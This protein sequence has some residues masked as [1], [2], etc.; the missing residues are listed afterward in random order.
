MTFRRK[1]Y[2]EKTEDKNQKT[3]E[4]KDK[5]NSKSRPMGALMLVLKSFFSFVLVVLFL[6]LTA[7]MVVLFTPYGQNAAVG[8]ATEKIKES[9]GIDI[10]I[11]KVSL[12]WTTDLFLK[13]V[14]IRDHRADT[15]FCAS[16]LGTSV[17]NY[18]RLYNQN[19]DLS[20]I[21]SKDLVF[22]LKTYK[23]ESK[24]NLDVFIEKF[25]KKDPNKKSTF[26]MN[27]DRVILNNSAFRIYNL[28]DSIAKT[29]TIENINLDT[30]NF[31]IEN[32]NFSISAQQGSFLMNDKLDVRDIKTNFS[33]EKGSI[34]AFNTHIVTPNSNVS[35][36]VKFTA[37]DGSFS[38]FLQRVGSEIYLKEASIGTEDI[39]VFYNGFTP[40]KK[41]NVSGMLQNT[42]DDLSAINADISVE[43]TSL[44]G[45]FLM[46]NIF[47]KKQKFTIKADVK[48]IKTSYDHLTSLMPNVLGKS[49]P[50]QL[51]NLDFI[52]GSG[53]VVYTQKD[54]NSNLKIYS[55]KGNV[56][57]GCDIK[58]ID[59]PKITQYRAN[60]IVQQM[61][62]GRILDVKKLKEVS[63]N[64]NIEGVG[65]EFT[66][67][68]KMFLQSKIDKIGLG[69]QLYQAIEV[70]GYLRDKKFEGLIN[71]KDRKLEM[72]LE[73]TMGKDQRGI[74]IY[75][76]AADVKKINLNEMEIYKDSIANAKALV[77]IKAT[78]NNIDKIRGEISI[79]G[80]EIQREQETFSF[81]PIHAKVDLNSYG[82]RSIVFDSKEAIE[83]KIIG[84]YSFLEINKIVKNSI[85]SIYQNY[86]PEKLKQG[87]FLS[88]DLKVQEKIVRALPLPFN[89]KDK[90]EIKGE[91]DADQAIFKLKANGK[92]IN[93]SGAGIENVE[94]SVD[95][96][97]QQYK[98]LFNIGK[99]KTKIYEFKDIELHSSTANDTLFLSSKAKG[100]KQDSFNINIYHTIDK[101][102]NW[103]FGVKN[104]NMVLKN[105]LWE[106][107][108]KM[109]NTV[110]IS[111]DY[112]TFKFQS[113]RLSHREQSINFSGEI[114]PKKKELH[115]VL[116]KV[117]LEA[118]MPETEKLAVEG[119]A[120]GHISV[121][122][123][124]GMKTPF[125]DF[126]I[127]NLRVNEQNMG[128]MS[129]T[130]NANDNLSVFK[131][132]AN[133]TKENEN[134]IATTGEIRNSE[135]RSN[136][137][138]KSKI[139][140][141]ELSALAPFLDGAL[142]KLKAKVDGEFYLSGRATSPKINGELQL[143][144]ASFTI[145][146]LNV[147]TKIDNGSKV[148]IE[149][150]KFVFKDVWVT[151]T[152][153]NTRASLSGKIQ[154]KDFI[155]W[156]LD[157]KLDTKGEK[158]L[159]L[160]T[161]ETDNEMFYGTVFLIGNGKL[162][163][164][165]SALTISGEGR[166]GE[167]TTFY[168]PLRDVTSV[169][170]D[171]FIS[172]VSKKEKIQD[173]EEND[174][175]N[176]SK[177][178]G[179]ELKF[180]IDLTP[181]ALVSII[182]D[183]KTQSSLTAKGVGTI[184]MEINTKGKFNM[185]GD[186]VT[187][188][189]D[190]NFKYENIINKKFKLLPAGA[191]VWNGSPLDAMLSNMKAVYTLYT[192]PSV[193]MENY[194]AHN[195]IKTE[196]ELTLEGNLSEPLPVF[197]IKFPETSAS[198]SSE[199]EYVLQDADKKQLQAFS[200]LLQGNFMNDKTL[201]ENILSHNVLESASGIF[202]DILNEQGSG[203]N[204]GLSYEA[205]KIS[206]D[207]IIDQ[208]DKLGVSF[209]TKLIDRVYLNG[210]IGIPLGGQT[211]TSIAGNFELQILLNKKGTLSGKIFNRENELHQYY[212]EKIGY[213]QGVGLS[214]TQEFDTFKQLM[215]AMIKRKRKNNQ[216][217]EN[218]EKEN[219]GK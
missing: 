105:N 56:D 66:D 52:T 208:G 211:Q 99:I 39:N 215:K 113:L 133:L 151:D 202:N 30:K 94:I 143:K 178:N 26:K 125:S 162:V 79:K 12:G 149:N 120:N 165:T 80:L 55:G 61:D 112:K 100:E 200:L 1:K 43:N 132:K 214:Y 119:Q 115:F 129:L 73:G 32:G 21:Y 86:K 6:A 177:N 22:N 216:Q 24:T 28:N 35:A 191:I 136:I 19:L 31:L 167:G 183:P 102:Q 152:K 179:L 209:N 195:K 95:N 217:K 199:I 146:Y 50:K 201:G 124:N 90:V 198:I 53:I 137:A 118:V 5:N 193:L 126:T 111:S 110:T 164:E 48:N 134:V 181:Q 218:K 47:D 187:V 210:K 65:F 74:N 81:L 4:K 156:F 114:A 169:G 15:L 109:K 37:K 101:K 121:I 93:V 71:V 173:K 163:G 91:M 219:E 20:Y 14:L 194:T 27:V 70:E 159:V 106:F 153:E 123:N 60:A 51:K 67:K 161:K 63:G 213:T 82:V 44:M 46:E 96:K 147:E 13:D 85:G 11:G 64:I 77:E 45:D 68:G 17:T 41:I 189:G 127:T 16:K 190:Y 176:T 78:G 154:H 88:F 62:L 33:L 170:D 3:Q 42:L 7:I 138:L 204:L 116:D 197:D 205:S 8:F 145:P 166:T 182:V 97:N 135:K 122:E 36:D 72:N 25:G 108:P 23:G 171:S 75:N 83:G 89:T 168:V 128:D 87:Q 18:L 144:D 58:D 140:D 9:S 76:F 40:G 59:N 141:L 49:L 192:D 84:V 185:W 69:R 34:Q 10:K 212:L 29:M 57:F 92:K 2:I 155:Q 172:F 150:N 54:L 184:L 203:L 180:D 175:E 157:L 38:N 104:S 139:K 186:F 196:V 188:S 142:S 160:N 98:T 206:P 148:Q 117:S 131:I 107:D 158:F 103:V 207:R 130:I 174:K